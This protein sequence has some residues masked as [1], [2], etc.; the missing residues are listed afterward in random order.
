MIYIGINPVAFTIGS[1][2]L[3]W[4]AV[5]VILAIVFLVWWSISFAKA[6]GF[7]IKQYCVSSRSVWRDPAATDE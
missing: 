6:A 2:S 7:L 4:Y 3:G 1:F 5:M